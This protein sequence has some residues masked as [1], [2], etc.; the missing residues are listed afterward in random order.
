MRLAHES[1]TNNANSQHGRSPLDYCRLSSSLWSQR[2]ILSE[3]MPLANTFAQKIVMPFPA[4]HPRE[5]AGRL[6][7]LP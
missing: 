2:S 4:V 6:L 7:K 1:E 5:S 3:P